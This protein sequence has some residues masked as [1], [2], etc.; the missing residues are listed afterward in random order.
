MKKQESASLYLVVEEGTGRQFVGKLLEK[1]DRTCKLRD[2]LLIVERVM[3]QPNSQQQQIAIN[4]SPIM[5]TFNIDTWEFKWSGF[6]E[7]TDERLIS[8]YEKFGTQ[9]R[10][11][12]SGL[13]VAQQLPTT[14]VV[15]N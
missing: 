12:R 6:H 1:N 8:S 10:A 13:S 2:P 9:I 5:H 7:V 4:I 15:P 14:R 11:A 3:A